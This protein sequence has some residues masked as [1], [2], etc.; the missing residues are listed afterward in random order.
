MA[1]RPRAQKTPCTRRI[2]PFGIT[3]PVDL[4]SL[5][6]FTKVAEQKSFTRAGEQLKLPKSRVSARISAL[7]TE[8]GTRLFQRST[9]VVELSEDGRRLLPRAEQLLAEADQIETLFQ[10]SRGLRGTVR[11]DLPV[12]L[13]CDVVIPRLPEWFATYPNV[14]LLFSTTD[15]RVDVLRE[16][17][18]CVVRV[19]ALV[20]STLLARKIGTLELANAASPDYLERHGVP[21]S[22][23]DLERHLVVHYSLRFGSDAPSFEWQADGVVHE[24]PMNSVLTVNN[25]D[26]YRTA[27]LAGLGIIQA[28]RIGL[29]SAFANGQLVEILPSFR[30]A[31]MPVSIVHAYGRGVPRRVRAAMTWLAKVLAPRCS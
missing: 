12:N 3:I 8:L 24:H 9:R 14:E 2:V 28:P 11:V 4:D 17:F 29:D 31:P 25:A 15:R 16:G 7:E 20:D 19:G 30:A 5:R 13:A 6:I 10:V 27:C 21:R 1:T 23:D 22:P 26:A 18:D